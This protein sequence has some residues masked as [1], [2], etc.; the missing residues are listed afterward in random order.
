MA[1]LRPPLLT[2]EAV[3]SEAAY[4][5]RRYSGG[6]EGLLELVAR[7]VVRPE[8]RLHEEVASVVALIRKYGGGSM[9]L[10]DACL[11]RMTEQRTDCV[12]LTLD[13]Q[14]RDVFRRN[15]RRSIPTLLPAKRG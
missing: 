2:C 14:F 11:V 4:L 7:E 10:A 1:R 13:T 8:F 6:P 12:L 15:G 9:D 3:V 5:L